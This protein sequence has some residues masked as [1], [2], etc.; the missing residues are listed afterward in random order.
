MQ[1]ME[2]PSVWLYKTDDIF[3]AALTSWLISGH[4]VNLFLPLYPP[5]VGV[6]GTHCDLGR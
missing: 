6:S 1:L 3:S 2:L 5:A 4:V